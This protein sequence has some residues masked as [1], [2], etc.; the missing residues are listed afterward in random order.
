MRRVRG[1]IAIGLIC[2]SA[3]IPK[4]ETI[5]PTLDLKGDYPNE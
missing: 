3:C 2:L 5:L 4:S 1:L